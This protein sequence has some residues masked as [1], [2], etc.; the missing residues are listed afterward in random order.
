MERTKQHKVAIVRQR[1]F[2]YPLTEQQLLF[3]RAVKEC[4][5]KKGITR[6]ELIEKMIT[7][8]PEFFAKIKKGQ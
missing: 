7:C 4:G 3:K 1:P 8:I 6:D 2:P 5:I